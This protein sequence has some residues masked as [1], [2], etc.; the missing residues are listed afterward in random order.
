MREAVFAEPF[1]NIIFWNGQYYA[2]IYRIFLLH[3]SA[4]SFYYNIRC[5]AEQEG[6]NI[7]RHTAPTVKLT[8]RISKV[9]FKYCNRKT[10]SDFSILL[11]IAMLALRVTVCGILPIE[12]YMTSNLNLENGPKVK[13]KYENGK[14]VF[15]FIFV[16]NGN[17][18]FICHHLRD[19]R[20]R[21]V[22]T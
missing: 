19:I 9:R 6:P 11:A 12:L 14:A 10:I 13:C 17:V 3:V 16:G 18:C 20:S 15:D 7:W 2:F 22:H 21:N 8:I 4:E 1:K 5:A